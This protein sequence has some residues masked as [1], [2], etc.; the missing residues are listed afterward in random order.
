MVFRYPIRIRP[1][2][3]IAGS[4]HWL[5]WPH[6]GR[7]TPFCKATMLKSE[8]ARRKI[9]RIVIRSDFGS[10]V[11]HASVKMPAHTPSVYARRMAASGAIAEAISQRYADMPRRVQIQN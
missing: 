11:N 6:P 8:P 5:R 3:E 4:M 7:T 9:G 2:N 1:E 10:R